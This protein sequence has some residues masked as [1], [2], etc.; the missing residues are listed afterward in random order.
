MLRRESAQTRR[1]RLTT[2]QTPQARSEMHTSI[3]QK[4]AL[5]LRCLAPRRLNI[6]RPLLDARL[7][8][9]AEVQD[10]AELAHALRAELEGVEVAELLSDGEGCFDVVA[11]V[12]VPLDQLAGGGDV[13][14]DRLLG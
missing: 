14:G 12:A 10:V 1:F 5:V 6:L 7:H 8:S 13:F 3:Q 4:P 11:A 9:H 2:Q